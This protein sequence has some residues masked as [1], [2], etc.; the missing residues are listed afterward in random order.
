MAVKVMKIEANVVLDILDR[1][2]Q[3]LLDYLHGLPSSVFSIGGTVISQVWYCPGR[4]GIPRL[5][6][7]LYWHTKYSGTRPDWNANMKCIKQIYNAIVE[8]LDLF[9][10]IVSL[11]WHGY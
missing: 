2:G 9:V 5:L 1:F 10:N 3:M 6:L 4:T 11:L 7:C 8:H